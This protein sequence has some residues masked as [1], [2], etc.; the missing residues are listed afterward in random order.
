MARTLLKWKQFKSLIHLKSHNT[1]LRDP[2]WIKPSSLYRSPPSCHNHR[3]D[4]F[5]SQRCAAPHNHKLQGLPFNPSVSVCVYL[6]GVYVHCSVSIRPQHPP[7]PIKSAW[8]CLHFCSH[9]S[10]IANSFRGEHMHQQAWPNRQ[11]ECEFYTI[12]YKPLV[13]GR[14]LVTYTHTQTHQHPHH[15][16]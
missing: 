12:V 9:Q 4:L 13:C 5:T 2:A 6:S 16:Q 7:R 1:P 14:V 15:T 11:F 3:P 8:W 10:W